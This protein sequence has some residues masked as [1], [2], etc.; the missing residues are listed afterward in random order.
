MTG[1]VVHEYGIA[2]INRSI[3]VDFAEEEVYERVS[4]LIWLHPIEAIKALHDAHLLRLNHPEE[5][6]KSRGF[7][8]A[9]EE[10]IQALGAVPNQGF[11]FIN[12]SVAGAATS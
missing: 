9:A 2:F 8:R 6:S 12:P 5:Q 4:Q 11:H 10:A 3:V 1:S 7:L